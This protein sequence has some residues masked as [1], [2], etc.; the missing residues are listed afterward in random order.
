MTI[1]IGRAIRRLSAMVQP[2]N[3]KKMINNKRSMINKP[4]GSIAL[5]CKL[6]TVLVVTMSMGIRLKEWL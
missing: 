2:T 3:E 1:A 5:D 6:A 4:T